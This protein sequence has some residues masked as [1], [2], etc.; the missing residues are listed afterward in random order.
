MSYVKTPMGKDVNYFPATSTAHACK[1]K[2][3]HSKDS[4][5]HG[6]KHSVSAKD[7]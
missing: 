4:E 2:I 3:T 5:S 7:W 6:T 1:N